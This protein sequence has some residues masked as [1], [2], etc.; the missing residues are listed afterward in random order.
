MQ[1][2]L[3]FNLPEEAEEFKCATEGTDYM[4]CLFDIQQLIREKLKYGHD[5]KTADEALEKIQEVF[6]EI[7]SNHNVK[8]F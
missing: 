7:L 4:C 2:E 6:F 1:A 8:T 5:Y 3:K